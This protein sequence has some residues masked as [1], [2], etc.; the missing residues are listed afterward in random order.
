MKL[1][2]TIANHHPVYGSTDVVVRELARGLSLSYSEY[3]K[4]AFAMSS[5]S[6]LIS[7]KSLDYRT[8]SVFILKSPLICLET[9]E[10]QM[11]GVPFVLEEEYFAR[12]SPRDSAARALL[13]FFR[14]IPSVA[15]TKRT[16]TFMESAGLKP[17]L[18][19]P[20]T[21]RRRG[22][23]KRGHILYVGKMIGSKNPLLVLK[24]AEALK[25]EEFVMI[26]AGPMSKEVGRRAGGLGN[27][28]VIGQ[29]VPREKLFDYYSGAKL[30]LHPAFK[31]PVGFV[32]IE[33]L[34]TQ[35]PV[36][37]S[38]GA[39]A[40]D[41]LPGEW[42][43]DPG[44]WRD[45]LSKAKSIIQNQDASTKKADEIFTTEHLDISDRYFRDIA[46][47]IATEIISKW[48]KLLQ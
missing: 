39:G 8:P 9:L 2:D 23:R 26:G 34:S 44:D 11:R 10:A 37:A 3:T 46:G 43:A 29:A 35:T 6:S 5:K 48:P 19:P 17:F 1:V 31:D 33:A 42:V 41:Y 7:Y 12:N 30:L 18:V 24:L 16:K 45:W 28:R 38:R 22:K 40:S 20:A 32:I 47:S 36:L 4:P 15:L 14:G 13:R 21:K 25:D 27:V